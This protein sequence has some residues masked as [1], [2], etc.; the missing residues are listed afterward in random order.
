MTRA[1]AL[2]VANQ[3]KPALETALKRRQRKY[4]YS[5]IIAQQKG[6]VKTDEL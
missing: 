5:A 4:F 2:K 1:E 6:F 3:K